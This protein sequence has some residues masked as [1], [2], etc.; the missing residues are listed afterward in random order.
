MS[1]FDDVKKKIEEGRS[2][3][4]L[5]I[6][7][8]YPRLANQIGVARSMW[9]I[10]G[11]DPGTGK[12]SFVDTTYILGI[13][14]WY[15]KHRDELDLS[16]KVILRSME[17]SKEYRVAK[18]VCYRLLKKYNILVDVKTILTLHAD[19]PVVD[20]DL[21]EKIESCREYF[22]EMEQEMVTVIDG[23]TNPTGVYFGFL[24][25]AMNNGTLYRNDLDDGLVIAEYN[26]NAKTK[27]IKWQKISRDQYPGDDLP[28]PTESEYFPDNK[29]EVVIPIVDHIGEYTSESGLTGKQL[30]DKAGEYIKR[31]RDIFGYSPV[32]VVQFN[33]NLSDSRRRSGSRL[34]PEEQDFMGSSTMFQRADMGLALFNPRRYDIS[35]HLGY[36]IQSF[37]DSNQNNRFRSLFVLKNSYGNADYGTGMSFIGECGLYRQLPIKMTKSDFR[38]HVNFIDSIDD[39]TIR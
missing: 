7:S 3:K 2:G 11:G 36:N 29:K 10:V 27:K 13:W 20:D 16:I 21:M 15:K 6:P 39:R 25:Y 28:E 24:D 8:P 9:T 26:G 1:L 37:T 22:E 30:L 34:Q 32:D 35:Q 5:W 4:Q 31:L 38:K 18:W 12:S 23:A 14:D 17:R 33:R 19:D